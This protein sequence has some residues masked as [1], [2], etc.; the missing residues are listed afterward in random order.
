MRGYFAP[1]FGSPA[2][3][4]VVSKG[5]TNEWHG[6]VWEFLRNDR[7]DARNT[8]DRTARK[9]PF[10]QNQYGGAIDGP[11]KKDKLFFHFNHEQLR[12]RQSF[13]ANGNLPSGQRSS[14]RW[15]DTSCFVEPLLN[16]YGNG[17]VH[18][19]DTDGSKTVD[20]GIFKNF[21]I[22]EAKRLQFRYEAFNVLNNTNYN[23]PGSSVSAPGAFGRITAAQPAR[24]MQF[25]MKF[26][27]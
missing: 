15:L 22:T 13:S 18:Y 4:S 17:G 9:P 11:I 14:T 6:A 16:T 2:I 5:G 21:S 12:A 1:E 23:R 10:R 24:V 26:Y 20:V 8:F 19:L 25:G 7:L 3:V 27:F